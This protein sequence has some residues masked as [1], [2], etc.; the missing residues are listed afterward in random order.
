MPPLPISKRRAVIFMVTVFVVLLLLHLFHLYLFYTRGVSLKSVNFNEEHNF[1]SL[2]ATLNLAFSGYLLFYIFIQGKNR[3]YR[4]SWFVLCII[5]C[6]L[7]VDE[8]GIIHEG[9]SKPYR[10][11]V[12]QFDFL[13]FFWV[14]PYSMLVILFVVAFLKFFLHLPKKYKWLFSLSGIIFVFGAIGMEIIGAPRAKHFGREDY[15]YTTYNTIEECMEF[16]G[17]I[18]FNYTLMSYIED[19]VPHRKKSRAVIGKRPNS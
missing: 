7:A 14:V 3:P 9:L 18:L 10:Q 19:F 8:Y 1:P 16:I 12:D 17:I 4:K 15:L 6:F 2:F 13:Y 11:Y 5:F